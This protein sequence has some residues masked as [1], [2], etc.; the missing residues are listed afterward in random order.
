MNLEPQVENA[1]KIHRQK[2]QLLKP[3]VFAPLVVLLLMYLAFFIFSIGVDTQANWE[4]DPIMAGMVGFSFLLLF[5]ALTYLLSVMGPARREFESLTRESSQHNRMSFR[6]FQGALHAVS[7]GVGVNTP[8]LVVLE[9][10]T[11]NTLSFVKDSNTVGVTRDALEANLDSSEIE[12]VM[13]HELAH[14]IAGDA[15]KPPKPFGV[16]GLV[17]LGL[18]ALALPIPLVIP[19]IGNNASTANI[20]IFVSLLLPAASIVT[21]AFV[22]KKPYSI[23]KLNPYYHHKDIL[24]DSVAAKLTKNPAALMSAIEKMSELMRRSRYVPKDTICFTQL[25]IGPLKAWPIDVDLEKPSFA[26]VTAKFRQ[27]LPQ[28][29]PWLQRERIED[30]L[31]QEMMA[32]FTWEAHLI[33]DRLE[34]LR[35]IKANKWEAFEVRGGRPIVMPRNWYT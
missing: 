25:F 18:A 5:M 10:A 3:L 16:S 15:L 8:D 26:A 12:A 31:R 7:I 24:A 6:K 23:S 34:N 4:F 1:I 27:F 11:V 21:S 9:M 19:L 29:D 13:A 22:M 30:A 33:R 35:M 17:L 14:V 2:S 28:H 32:F 20:F